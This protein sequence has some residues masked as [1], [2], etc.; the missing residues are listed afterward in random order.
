MTQLLVNTSSLPIFARSFIGFNKF[1]NS[2][3][4]EYSN[5]QSNQTYPPFNL[6]DEGE[7]KYTLE[8]ALAG[9]N[10]NNITISVEYDTLHIASGNIEQPEKTYIYRGLA[11]R[12]FHRSFKLIDH[13]EVDSATMENG[14]LYISLERRVPERLKLKNIPIKSK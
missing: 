2:L 11:A 4:S 13:V 3:E 12:G 10:I 14:M 1:I 7:D 8:M 9:F 5:D 6:I